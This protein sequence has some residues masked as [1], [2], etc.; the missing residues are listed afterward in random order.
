[1]FSVCELPELLEL[2]ELLLLFSTFA[3]TAFNVVSSESRASSYIGVSFL[4]TQV[5]NLYPSLVG[6]CGNFKVSPLTTIISSIL[7]PPSVSNLIVIVSAISLIQV[8]FNVISLVTTYI[9][10]IISPFSFVHPLKIYPSF[11]AI[12]NVIVSFSL[13]VILLRLFPPSVL[14]AIVYFLLPNVKRIATTIMAM[15]TKV[16]SSPNNSFLFSNIL[17][18]SLFSPS[19]FLKLAFQLHLQF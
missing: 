8:A 9:L 15:A 10:D 5:L 11:T 19:T 17:F 18:I 14:N 4:S 3:H 7:L 12:G 1:M 16:P 6:F 13:A 2:F